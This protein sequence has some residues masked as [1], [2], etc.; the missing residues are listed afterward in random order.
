M[1]LLLCG[2]LLL[3]HGVMRKNIFSGLLGILMLML[4]SYGMIFF[5]P[6]DWVLPN[7]KTAAQYKLDNYTI[8][9]GQQPGSDFYETY[10]EVVRPDGK[11][12]QRWIDTD[13]DKIWLAWTKKVDDK[14]YFCRPLTPPTND[15]TPWVDVVTSEVYTRLG[16]AAPIE[17]LEYK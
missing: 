3:A 7:R 13:D 2:A 6:F 16:G 8:R 4:G 11:I 14:V 5:S 10:V 12:A 1:G 9:F 15:Y 17:A